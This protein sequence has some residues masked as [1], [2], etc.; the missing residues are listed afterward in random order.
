M[1]RKCDRGEVQVPRE[2]ASLRARLYFGLNE[3]SHFW[4]PFDE[5]GSV[6]LYVV[7]ERN[8]WE[9]VNSFVGRRKQDTPKPVRLRDRGVEPEVEGLV[10]QD[11]GHP[12][13]QDSKRLVCGCRDDA[14][15]DHTFFSLRV[16]PAR[17]KT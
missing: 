13:V 5:V 11:D 6:I 12:V 7:D 16:T 4:D 3:Q 9:L 1:Q 8:Y 17:P 2:I 10:L 15:R 14:A